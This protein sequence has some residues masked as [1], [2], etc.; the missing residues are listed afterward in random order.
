[1][2][3]VRK[4][5]IKYSTLIYGVCDGDIDDDD[6]DEEEEEDDDDDDYHDYVDVDDDNTIS[7]LATSWMS[8]PCS[9]VCCLWWISFHLALFRTG[10]EKAEALDMK[11]QL[12]TD[13]RR[14]LKEEKAW[15]PKQKT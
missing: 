1:M 12:V 4:N 14:V 13:A 8:R 11:E 5:D 9:L 15:Q 7:W 2:M 10:I 6:D 3:R